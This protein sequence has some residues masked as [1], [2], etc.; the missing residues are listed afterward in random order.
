[1]TNT[2]CLNLRGK[3]GSQSSITVRCVYLPASFFNACSSDYLRTERLFLQR[4]FASQ[5][6]SP[7][8]SHFAAVLLE[9]RNIAFLKNGKGQPRTSDRKSLIGNRRDH[10][11]FMRVL[12]RVKRLRAE[13]HCCSS[14]LCSDSLFV[15]FS[16]AAFYAQGPRMDRQRVFSIFSSGNSSFRDCFYYFQS[17]GIRFEALLFNLNLRVSHFCNSKSRKQSAKHRHCS[18]QEI[19]KF[20]FFVPTKNQC[21]K[22]DCQPAH[23]FISRSNFHFFLRVLGLDFCLTAQILPSTPETNFVRPVRRLFKKVRSVCNHVYL[24]TRDA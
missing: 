8:F 2:G 13:N 17:A 5:M 19:C 21:E 16:P 23:K 10:Y 15:F 14:L 3:D 22:A 11:D 18:T 4:P 7:V 6:V 24:F 9:I 12:P 20:G 1:M